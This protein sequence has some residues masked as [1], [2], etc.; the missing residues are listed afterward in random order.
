MES[1][2]K[3]L[4]EKL[5]KKEISPVELLTER[6]EKIDALDSKVQAFIS[7]DRDEALQEAKESEKR[8]LA[9]KPL[10]D[11]DGIP[12]GIKDNIVIKGRH[13]ACAS[14]ILEGFISPY[15]ATVIEKLQNHGLVCLGRLNMDEFAM[16]SSTENS[17]VHVTKNPYD[18]ERAPGGSSGGSAASVAAGYLPVSLGSDTG[19]SIRQPAAFTGIVGLK[20]TYGTVSRYGLI[21]FA[22]SLDQIGPLSRSVADSEIIYRIISG[23][24]PKDS[25]SVPKT[26]YKE[27]AYDLKSLRIG[28][29]EDLL[30]GVSPEVKKSFNDCL[31]FLKKEV[32]TNGTI[33]TVSLPH[34]KY[35]IAVYYLTATSEASANL[36]RFDGVRYGRRSASA[37]NLNDIYEMSRT[38]GFGPEVKRRILLGTYALSSG[39]YDAFYGKA[40]KTRTLI[41]QD[42]EKAFEKLDVILMPTAP[43]PPFKIGEKTSNPVEMYLSDVMTVGASLAGIPALSVPGPFE[44]LPIGIQ[45]QGNYF[46]EKLLFDLAQKIQMAFPAPPPVL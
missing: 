34:Q 43:S 17:S 41:K 42:Y 45:L 12:I 33:E 32:I 1:E 27:P 14:K 6:F 26:M 28:V 3:S 8:L 24:D 7:Q 23:H 29:A 4:S 46:S 39:Y 21:A 35:G 31:D 36:A 25:T 44:K 20:P 40:Q 19:G 30:E 2:L 11:Y 13:T 9:G 16:G 37:K 15:S 38:E 22:S 18:L 5:K 10:S